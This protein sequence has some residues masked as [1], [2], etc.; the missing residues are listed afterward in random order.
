[1]SISGLG[2][3]N[4]PSSTL[5][6]SPLKRLGLFQVDRLFSEIKAWSSSLNLDH[7][8]LL[9]QG[10]EGSLDELRNGDLSF[11]SILWALSQ[12]DSKEDTDAKKC[13]DQLTDL[14]EKV[15][16]EINQGHR[17]QGQARHHARGLQCP[18]GERRGQ[19]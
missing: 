9:Y 10:I 1:M 18:D 11:R 7:I 2:L 8:G 15:K 13:K 12:F 5:E 17:H 3:C 14:L 19:R 4:S 6:D 16:Q